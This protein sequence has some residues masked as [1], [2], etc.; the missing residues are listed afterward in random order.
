MYESTV[1]QM[2]PYT[3][4]FRFNGRNQEI[5]IPVAHEWDV[6]ADKITMGRTK[7]ALEHRDSFSFDVR[8][9]LL[10]LEQDGSKTD[11]WEHV[12]SCLETLKSREYGKEL[13][14]ELVSIAPELGYDMK[15]LPDDLDARVEA[16]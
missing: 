4:R 2:G 6:F 8:H 12:K 5:E 16:L 14:R 10:M 1:S 15:G 9:C 11:F 3:E 13:L 7:A